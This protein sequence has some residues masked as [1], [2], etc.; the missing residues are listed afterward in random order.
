MNFDN[1]QFG[2]KGNVERRSVEVYSFHYD[3]LS[4]ELSIQHPIP[5]Q[6]KAY[7]KGGEYG[8]SAFLI[9][10]SNVVTTCSAG[11]QMPKNFLR[12]GS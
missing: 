10:L 9:C 12:Y 4:A 2:I 11:S 6:S 8:D 1:S 3:M 5:K 7:I